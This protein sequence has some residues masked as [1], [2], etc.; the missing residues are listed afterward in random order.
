M[1]LERYIADG[2]SDSVTPMFD[3]ALHLGTGA[4]RLLAETIAASSDGSTSGYVIGGVRFVGRRV[5]VD[6]A[7]ARS[8]GDDAEATTS[9]LL[10][11]SIRP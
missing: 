11:V 4:V 7:V 9:P 10:A 1:Q 3:L 8:F 6:L 5:A 2:Y